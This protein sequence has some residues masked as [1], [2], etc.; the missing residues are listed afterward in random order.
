MNWKNIL[1][2]D[3]LIKSLLQQ[4]SSH[5]P[6]WLMRQ[7]GRYLSE[8][9]QV[10][11]KAGS[12]M[13]LCQNPDLATQVTL[14]PVQKFDLDAAILFSDILVIPDALGLGLYFVENEGPKFQYPINTLADI[15]N[16]TQDGVLE[17][18]NYVFSTIKNIQSELANRIPLIGFS[19][20]PFTLACYML[21]GGSS[22]DYAKTKSWLY[23]HPD[24]MHKL[25]DLLADIVTKYLNSQIEAGVDVVMLFDSW[26]GILSD[27][28]YLEFSLAYL[29]KVI[30]NLNKSFNNRII[31]KIVFTKGGGVW[32]DQ[33]ASIGANCIGLDWGINIGNAKSVIKDRAAIQG[34]LDPVILSQ[35]NK[36]AIKVEVKRILEDYKRANDGD[37]SG[38][39]FNL[40]HGILPTAL[41]D[42]VSYLIDL[43]HEVTS[44]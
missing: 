44:K 27:V 2:N 34:N 30:V 10:R 14:Q 11:A 22:R 43:V 29:Q 7:A 41:E 40:G 20:S 6:I 42:N 19:G 36:S 15:D 13:A 1:I 24:Y 16:L 35:S 12:F 8:Y 17:N 31:P 23:S 33:I 28:H 37:I 38:H 3:S 21:E 18:L 9:R 25:L 39:V 26:G 32:L 4:P 5:T